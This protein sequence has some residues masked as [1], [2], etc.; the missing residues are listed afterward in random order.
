MLNFAPAKRIE[1]RD[2]QA[3]AI[4]ALRQG[5]RAQQRRQILPCIP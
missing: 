1:L 4:E 5:I 2:Y 3:D